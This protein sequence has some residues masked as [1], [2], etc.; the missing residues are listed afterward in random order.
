M[1]FT[2]LLLAPFRILPFCSFYCAQLHVPNFRA[3]S[4]RMNYTLPAR[5]TTL[6]L[7]IKLS[8]LTTLY[9]TR[10]NRVNKNAL[11]Y[12]SG[13]QVAVAF[14]SRSSAEFFLTWNLSS[15]FLLFR[16]YHFCWI[17]HYCC[18]GSFCL[19]PVPF[20]FFKPV[21]SFLRKQNLVPYTISTTFSSPN[22]RG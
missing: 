3:L 17:L 1:A 22:S 15:C 7:A 14:F 19:R 2:I 4:G 18:S 16:T 20:F 11:N 6:L 13:M 5:S 9:C 8:T 21:E 12:Y 10:Q